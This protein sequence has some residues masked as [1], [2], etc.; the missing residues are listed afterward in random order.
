MLR[1]IRGSVNLLVNIDPGKNAFP[2]REQELDTKTPDVADKWFRLAFSAR[3][4]GVVDELSSQSFFD[5]IAQRAT[6]PDLFHE[7]VIEPP[8]RFYIS[9]RIEG[10]SRPLPVAFCQRD[11]Y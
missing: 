7:L 4:L 9:G 6:Q 1:T 11:L 5:Y 2:S 10:L 8:E 3:P